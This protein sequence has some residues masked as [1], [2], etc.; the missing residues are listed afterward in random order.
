MKRENNKG[1]AICIF[2]EKERYKVFDNF[3]IKT[4]PK[5]CK[6]IHDIVSKYYNA[7]L[8]GSAVNYGVK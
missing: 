5:E 3:H 4:I 2:K 1:H 8:V 7:T 6:T